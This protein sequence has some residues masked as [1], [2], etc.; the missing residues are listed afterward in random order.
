MVKECVKFVENLTEEV[1]KLTKEIE[2]FPEEVK[3]LQ[4]IRC[5]GENS[6]GGHPFYILI[7]Y[8]EDGVKKEY[9]ELECCTTS[10][11]LRFMLSEIAL[12][13]KR[14]HIT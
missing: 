10:N 2:D 5:I 4:S 3:V 14:K 6:W 7:V 9:W 12:R 1:K 8:E 11:T 13:Y